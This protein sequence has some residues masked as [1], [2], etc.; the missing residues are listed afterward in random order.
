MASSQGNTSQT[1]TRWRVARY[2]IA[3]ARAADGAAA[4][5]VSLAAIKPRRP[6]EQDH[7]RDR[8]DEKAA[9]PRIDILAAGIADAEQDGGDQRA[10]QAAEAAHRDDQQEEHEVEHGEA[11]REPE[12]L[13]REAAA[14]RRKAAADREGEREQA[15]DID[16]DR[17]GHAPIVDRGADAG[18]DIGALEGVP[19][20]GHQGGADR[21]DEH[22]VGRKGARADGEL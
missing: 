2:A 14:E 4:A 22:P 19:Q 6:D 1:R 5:I 16:A 3:G 10:L 8:V 11:R 9:G 21:D 7:H 18:A 15:I 13:D 20:D 12:Q 17:L